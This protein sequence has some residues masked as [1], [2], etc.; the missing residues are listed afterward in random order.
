MITVHLQSIIQV[1]EMRM[2]RWTLGKTR[3]DHIRNE[4]LR[5]QMMVEPISN[6][7]EANRLKWFGHVLRRPDSNCCKKEWNK[8]PV[9]NRRG[10]AR[11]SWRTDLERRGVSE[12]DA[13]DRYEW[14]K[15]TSGPPRSTKYLTRGTTRDSGRPR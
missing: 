12:D 2:L 10:R 14:W 9:T 1:T 15:R 7:I 8:R 6:A 4:D 3:M 13:Q 11:T 5:R